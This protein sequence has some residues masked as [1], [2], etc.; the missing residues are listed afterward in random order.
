MNIIALLFTESRG[1]IAALIFMFAVVLI[2]MDGKRRRKLF[3]G[4]FIVLMVG[5]IIS[6]LIPSLTQQIT[7][8]FKSMFAIMN[9]NI[10][11]DDFGGNSTTGLDSR[12]IQFTGVLWTIMD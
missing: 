4:L 1:S 10:E 9:T 12:L 5:S 3:R 6:L 11:I 7:N 8:I 2:K